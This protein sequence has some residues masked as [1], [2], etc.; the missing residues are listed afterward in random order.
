MPFMVNW[1]H[2][3]QK[4]KKKRQKHQQLKLSFLA[5]KERKDCQFIFDASIPSFRGTH[6]HN[7]CFI[8]CSSFAFIKYQTCQN[9]PPQFFLFKNLSI[10]LQS[11]SGFKPD[12][13]FSY[14]K[15]QNFDYSFGVSL[16]GTLSNFLFHYITTFPKINLF[17]NA[18]ILCNEITNY[19]CLFTFGL[20]TIAC[21][22]SIILINLFDLFN[23]R[24]NFN[25]VLC[26]WHGI[27]KL[28]Y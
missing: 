17:F 23:P 1:K 22:L 26:G 14:G 19:F 7:T 25:E 28:Y 4:S 27:V 18:K 6:K 10:H 9:L 5:K 3:H 8:S 20:V 21:S 11:I 15:F 13:H 24:L 2:V 12:F 16:F